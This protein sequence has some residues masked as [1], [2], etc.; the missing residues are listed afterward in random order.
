MHELADAVRECGDVAVQLAF[1]DV[2]GPTV[3][4]A[5]ATL[6]GPVVLVPAFLAAGYHVRAEVPGEV[7]ASRHADV[8]VTRALGPDPALAAAQ[9]TRLLD[10]GWRPGDAVVLAAVGSTDVR[11]LDDV[12]VAARLLS[13]E[14]AAPV[15][16]AYA[17]AGEPTVAEAVS[18]LRAD[19]ATRVLVSPY[20]LAPGLFQS[21]LSEAG[22]DGVGAPL[23]V[24]S[25][26]VE[27][28]LQRYRAA[29]IR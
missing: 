14:L 7:G 20:L 29:L 26:V 4:Q 21:R 23:G 27:L 19:G 18:R 15:Q 28:V 16:P 25:A 2:L 17:V 1:V 9:H 8:R 10:V 5:L 22:A 11:A 12:R 13:Q 24:H 3:A 6:A